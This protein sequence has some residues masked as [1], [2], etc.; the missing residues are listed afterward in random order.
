[1]NQ[2]VESLESLQDLPESWEGIL[3]QSSEAAVTL[4]EAPK[5]IVSDCLEKNSSENRE[6]VHAKGRKKLGNGR[7]NSEPPLVEFS[8]NSP[9]PES[10]RH[11]P[12]PDIYGTGSNSGTDGEG[13]QGLLP[14]QPHRRLSP[15]QM[16][17]QGEFPISVRTAVAESGG[18]LCGFGWQREW[19]F[20]VA[21]LVSLRGKSHS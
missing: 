9:S 15:L 10:D 6:N 20:H 8:Q 17:H 13:R 14:L 7:S 16:D 1:M 19:G 11:E 18:F 2:V 5:E 4:Y 3:F 21:S 12:N